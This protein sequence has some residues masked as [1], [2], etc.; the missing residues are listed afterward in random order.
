MSSLWRTT[1]CS[2]Q[3]SCTSLPPLQCC[4]SKTPAFGAFPPGMTTA[5]RPSTGILSAWYFPSQDPPIFLCIVYMCIV[6]W[7]FL[8]MSH[9]VCCWQDKIAIISLWWQNHRRHEG[10]QSS[11][12]PHQDVSAMQ[13][14]GLQ[15]QKSA[16]CTCQ[17]RYLSSLRAHW[18]ILCMMH[19]SARAQLLEWV[20]A[21][22]ISRCM[23]ESVW[24][25]CRCARHI[26]RGW[27]GWCGV[28]CGWR[29]GPTGPSRA[30]TTGCASTLLPK[31]H[32]SD[33]H[34]TQP[35][36]NTI[37]KGAS[38]WSTWHTAP[39]TCFW[40]HADHRHIGTQISTF[41]CCA[42]TIA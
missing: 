18:D 8:V 16:A 7:S 41:F 29:L 42:Q 2:A 30:G 6:H 21:S 25:R 22:M 20:K 15:D 17:C 32:P 14:A 10:R 40:H 35:H 24:M 9:M 4:W 31:V 34:N 11:K 13:Q 27:G 38:C 5:W 1:C 12:S 23:A 33:Q 36:I 26:S 37:A 3:T 39:T 28:S 19:A